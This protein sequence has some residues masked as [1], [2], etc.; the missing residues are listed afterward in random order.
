MTTPRLRPEMDNSKNK[1]PGKPFV[2]EETVTGLPSPGLVEIEGIARL[3]IVGTY[4]PKIGDTL[5]IYWQNG[6]RKAVIA[7]S[8]RRGNV[9]PSPGQGGGIVEELFI[10]SPPG[11]GPLDVIYRNWNIVR[12]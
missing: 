1:D 2:T 3:P 5:T 8:A 11:G 4:K 7:L 9:V 12:P 10:G 6:V